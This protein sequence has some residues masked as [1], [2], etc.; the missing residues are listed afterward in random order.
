MRVTVNNLPTYPLRK[1][2]VARKVDN[3][4]WFYG[5]WDSKDEAERVAREIDGVVIENV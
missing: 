4:L 3:S 2:I 1:Y 5:T